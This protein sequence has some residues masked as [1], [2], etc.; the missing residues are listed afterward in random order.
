MESSKTDVSP[1]YIRVLYFESVYRRGW[2]GG[3]RGTGEVNRFVSTRLEN[4][5]NS[6]TSCNVRNFGEE[7]SKGELN[8]RREMRC[9]GISN[10]RER[11]IESRYLKIK[12]EERNEECVFDR[13]EKRKWKTVRDFIG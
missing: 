13:C 2:D 1:N 8:K 5:E 7:N 4:E 10:E 12:E 6:K 3:R 11:E 9:V